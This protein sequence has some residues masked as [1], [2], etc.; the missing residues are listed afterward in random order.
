MR[1]M[2]HVAAI[3]VKGGNG[4]PSSNPALEFSIHF[5]I[6]GLGKCPKPSLLSHLLFKYVCRQSMLTLGTNQFNIKK[7]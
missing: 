6:N 4:E 5:H 1:Y 3:S 7:N 2:R